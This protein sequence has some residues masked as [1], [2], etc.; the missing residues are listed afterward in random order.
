[1]PLARPHAQFT[2]IKECFLKGGEKHGC[3]LECP[4]CLF[5]V[6]QQFEVDGYVEVSVLVEPFV[7]LQAFVQ[8]DDAR[9]M[10]SQVEQAG[11]DV[12]CH[13][14]GTVTGSPCLSEKLQGSTHIFLLKGSHSLTSTNNT[15]STR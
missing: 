12:V 7:L 8:G 2:F 1:L 14:C 4:E 13:L 11:T 9:L 3:A 15:Y 10:A 6:S 5:G